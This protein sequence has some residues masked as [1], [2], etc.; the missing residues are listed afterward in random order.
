MDK[1]DRDLQITV[2]GAGTIGLSLAALHLAYLA[3]PSNLTI[4][5]VRLDLESHVLRSLPAL[6]PQGLH[7]CVSQVKLMSSVPIAV[8][9]QRYSP[10]MRS[11]EPCLQIRPVA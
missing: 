6:L 8:K 2:I 3:T 5:D 10:R 4:V 1:D 9:E 7:A 11:R